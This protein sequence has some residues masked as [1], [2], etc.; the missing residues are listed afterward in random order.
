MLACRSVVCILLAVFV[1]VGKPESLPAQG[2]ELRLA[3]EK[4]IDDLIRDTLSSWE[5][6]GAAVAIVHQEKGAIYL[7]GFGVRRLGGKDLVTP[8]TVFAISSCT[9]SFTTLAMAMLIDEKKMAWDDPV[10]KHLPYFRLADPLADANV[11][12]RDLVCH[13]TGIGGHEFLTYHSPWN[14][15]EQVRRI[16]KVKP[17]RSFRSGYE[18]QGIMFTAAGLAVARTSGR[19]W[20]D[21]VQKRIFDP[22]GMGGASFTTA[23]ALKAAD[24]AEPHVRNKEGKVVQV[25]WYDFKEPNPSVS[26]NATARDLSRYVQFQ[27]GDGTWQ[28]KPLV[29]TANLHEMRMPQTVMRLEGTERSTFPFTTQLSYGLGWVVYDYRGHPVAAH[30]GIVDGMRVQISLVPHS[31]LGVVVLANLHMTRMNLAL[32]NLIFDQ[33]LG[34]PYR[35]WNDYY[36]R[37][38]RFLDA[39]HQAAVKQRQDQRQANTR[40]T[41]P[42]ERY[43]G[44]YE[45]DAYGTCRLAVEDN[46][47]VWYWS[48]FRCPLE[49]YHFDTFI[50]QNEILQEPL[51]AMRLHADGTVA[52]LEVLGVDFQRQGR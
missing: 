33:M 36:Q 39:G 35:D 45:D 16:G 31:G 41:L 27:L 10:R 47:L 2:K 8:D 37:Q 13:R 11:T 6:P 29:S 4:A 24:R 7:K 40:P 51:L 19:R 22:L 17:S 9:K 21:F 48:T 3:G 28:G 1:V 5:V 26:I 44:T 42:L 30:A 14:L 12:L 20:E 49:H 32:S 38:V 34:L 25:P 46:R 23:Q 43:A 18:Y 15:E 50:V 52:G